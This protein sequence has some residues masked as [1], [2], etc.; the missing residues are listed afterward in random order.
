MDREVGETTS[1]LVQWKMIGRDRLARSVVLRK[2]GY[3]HVLVRTESDTWGG[4]IE[5]TCSH[6]AQSGTLAP[7]F[8][9]TT[10]SVGSHSLP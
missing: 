3:Q 7:R 1:Q 2:R 5:Y 4:A 10:E 9:S 8:R 6:V